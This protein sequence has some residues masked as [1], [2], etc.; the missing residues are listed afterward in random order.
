MPEQARAAPGPTANAAAQI[1]AQQQCRVA[2]NQFEHALN[3][4]SVCDQPSMIAALADP[5]SLAARREALQKPRMAPLRAFAAAIRAAHGPTPDFDP[6]DGGVAARMLL[7]LETPGPSI[8]RT[9]FVSA[10]NP[11]GTSANLRRFLAAAGIDRRQIVIWN[12]VPWMIHNGGRNRTPKAV[13]IRRGLLAVPGLLALLPHLRCVVM[14]GRVASMADAM[15][16]AARPEVLMIRIP[17]PSPTFVC[18]SPDVPQ[19][20]AAGLRTAT[21]CMGDA[22]LCSAQTACKPIGRVID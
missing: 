10:D 11:T 6:A 8:G 1:G 21:A 5:A 19:R 4:R 7:L 18:T 15:L 3:L 20:I 14:A 22:Q 13:E 9:G 16:R 17:H 2:S 12:T